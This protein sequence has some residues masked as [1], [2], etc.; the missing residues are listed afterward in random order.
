MNDSRYF[1]EQ[2]IETED[3]NMLEI[4]KMGVNRKWRFRNDGV[5]KSQLKFV[6]NGRPLFSF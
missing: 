6:I 5:G 4:V 1:I 2:Q 3:N